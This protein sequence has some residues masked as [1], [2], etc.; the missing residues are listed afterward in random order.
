VPGRTPE[1]DLLEQV[2]E[3]R[4]CSLV[5]LH[6][7]NRCTSASIPNYRTLF[8]DRPHPRWGWVPG[9]DSPRGVP[10]DATFWIVRNPSGTLF[11]SGYWLLRIDAIGSLTG[12]RIP[13][14]GSFAPVVCNGNLREISGRSFWITPASC[15]MGRKPWKYAY[16]ASLAQQFMPRG[17]SV[18]EGLLRVDSSRD[19]KNGVPRPTI[20]NR[21]PDLP[22]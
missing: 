2:C 22:G 9:P 13:I 7:E 5:V 17:V 4:W 11:L 10:L 15:R 19:E 1:Y 8:G 21:G 6:I 18:Y 3:I 20:L 14:E 16:I 12:A